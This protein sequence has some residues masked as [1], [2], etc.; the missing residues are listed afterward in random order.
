MARFLT[1][2]VSSLALASLLGCEPEKD[3]TG[4]VVD[5]TGDPTDARDRDGDGV[6]ADLDCDDR[7]PDVFP[8]NADICNGLDDDC[9]DEID[10]DP[11]IEWFLDADGD[12]FGYG[13]TS[14]GLACEGAEGSV[15]NGFDCDDSDASVFP[16]AFEICDGLD[17]NCDGVADDGAATHVEVDGSDTGTGTVDD[18]LGSIQAAIDSGDICVA[19]GPGTYHESL[20]IASGPLW[21]YSTQGSDSTII[22]AG[23]NGAGIS[24]RSAA[25]DLRVEGFSITNGYYE[26][27]GGLRV[28]GAEAELVDLQ[29][30]GNVA[31]M[32]GG[33]AY[34]EDADVSFEGLAAVGNSAD[35]GGGLYVQGGTVTI[36][37]SEI[38]QN[39]AYYG[40]GMLLDSCAMQISD[41]SLAE[42]LAGYAG[43]AIYGYSSTLSLD[44]TELTANEASNAYGGGMAIYDS[45]VELTDS[46]VDDNIASADNGAGVYAYGG[47][48]GL[49][50]SSF[51]GN[52]VGGGSGGGL[53]ALYGT[54]VVVDDV[55]FS[56]NYSAYGSG[57]GINLYYSAYMYGTDLYLYDNVVGSGAGAGFMVEYGG[58]LSIEGGEIAGNNGYSFG[59]GLVD[60]GYAY[61]HQVTVANNDATYVGGL[62]AR[63]YGGL[64]LENVVLNGNSDSESSFF[65]GG[66]TAYNYGAVTGNFVTLV[67][68]N[69]SYALQVKSYASLN[70]TNS[71]VA[72]NN[73]VGVD[74]TQAYASYVYGNYNDF[75]GNSSYDV[76]G[77]NDVED[78]VRGRSSISEDP[79]FVDFSGVPESDDLHLK[80]GSACEDAGDSSYNDA[81][82]SRADMGAYGGAGSDW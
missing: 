63:D 44:G 54:E 42:N 15:G 51:S 19:V 17:Q 29:L 14:Q 46:A 28:T 5:D 12:G 27:G 13:S 72:F 24:I 43:G 22:D 37:D 68:T 74:L 23:A 52:S 77:S 50:R 70:L 81:D 3:D 20:V 71:I 30:Y 11:D 73:G 82:G 79:E 38:D 25:S 39:E 35:N 59:A 18:P 10:E 16:G 41:S 31:G 47:T 7:D 55:T 76:Y 58:S 26:Y 60:G 45:W 53:Y 75:Y 32:N 65:G 8:G 1:L 80:S 61:L 40:A 62:G 21:L 2:A 57:A 49:T 36:S 78:A 56:E 34:L 64:T 9:D 67:G 33:A 4:P 66:I 69:A 6:S 48:L